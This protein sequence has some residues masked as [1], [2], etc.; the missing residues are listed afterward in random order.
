MCVCVCVL[1]PKTS[2]AK[3]KLK[4]CDMIIIFNLCFHFSKAVVKSFHVSYVFKY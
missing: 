2:S 4:H 3:R 1:Y